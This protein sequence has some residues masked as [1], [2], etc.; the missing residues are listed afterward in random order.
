MEIEHNEVNDCDGQNPDLTAS[1]IIAKISGVY[2]RVR[3][4]YYSLP[5][6]TDSV[7]L[8]IIE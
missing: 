5:E 2:V 6:S 3:D 4:W 7:T 8:A 1:D